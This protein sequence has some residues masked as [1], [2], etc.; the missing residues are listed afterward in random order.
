MLKTFL[1]SLLLLTSHP[2]VSDQVEIFDTDK[3]R[4]VQTFENTEAFQKTAAAI[5]HTATERVAELSPSLEKAVIVKI[6]LI[7]PQQ[8]SRPRLQINAGIREMFVVMPK[9]GRRK[10]WLILHTKEEETLVFEF[11]GSL[12][13]LKRLIHRE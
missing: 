4:V 3:E 6:P 12:E 8:L 9:H 5:L 10:P 1:L 11:S 2:L 7:P 13:E